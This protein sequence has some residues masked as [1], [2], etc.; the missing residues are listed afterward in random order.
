MDME[1]RVHKEKVLSAKVPVGAYV[2]FQEEAKGKGLTVSELLR[3]DY[4]KV[5]ERGRRD[6]KSVIK[7]KQ[8]VN[9]VESVHEVDDVLHRDIRVDG[10]SVDVYNQLRDV[11]NKFSKQKYTHKVDKKPSTGDEQKSE[12]E[13]EKGSLYVPLWVLILCPLLLLLKRG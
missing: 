8:K 13:S 1:N 5:D 4:F 6:K 2:S 3:R 7:S 11:A 10:N 9:N 12:V